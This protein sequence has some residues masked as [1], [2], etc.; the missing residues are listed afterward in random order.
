MSDDIALVTM[1]LKDMWKVHP[2]QDNSRVCSKC[3]QPV[4][5]YP[6]GQRVLQENPQAKIIC[7][8]CVDHKPGDENYPAG[9]ISDIM[10]EISESQ[11]RS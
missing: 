7:N 3:G 10:R 2:D 8:V 6:S 1:R 5:V 9:P 4:G 11:R